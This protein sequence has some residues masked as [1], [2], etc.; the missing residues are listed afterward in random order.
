MG[1]DMG[2]NIIEKERKNT[3]VEKHNKEKANGYAPG[4][5]T[6][7]GMKRYDPVQCQVCEYVSCCVE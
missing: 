5:D 2:K 7:C 3:E 1:A 6:V 4:N